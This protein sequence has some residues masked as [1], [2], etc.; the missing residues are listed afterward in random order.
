MELKHIFKNLLSRFLK[1]SH[2]LICAGRSGSVGTSPCHGNIGGPG[3]NQE[4]FYN[5]TCI[6]W[7]N[8]LKQ[9][10]LI[11]FCWKFR[12]IKYQFYTLFYVYEV[13]AKW[14]LPDDPVIVKSSDESGHGKR[15]YSLTFWPNLSPGKRQFYR[16]R[17]DLEYFHKTSWQWQNLTHVLTF[18]MTANK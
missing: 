4:V 9:C 13:I 10:S 15:K 3:N 17:V 11:I 14:S 16:V 7:Y 5:I 1:Y 12:C 18:F 6:L 8:T 2:G